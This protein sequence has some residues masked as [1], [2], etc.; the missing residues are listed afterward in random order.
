MKKTSKKN[1][2][3]KEWDDRADMGYANLE[4]VN[5]GDLLDEFIKF[6]HP[7]GHH[8]LIDLGTGTGKVA[9]ELARHAKYVY[10][11]D[12]SQR[13][14]DLAPKKKNISYVC[15][16]A[17]DIHLL[18]IKKTHGIVARMVFHHLN[19]FLEDVLEKSRNMLHEEGSF[20][21]CEGIPPTDRA[22]QN[23]KDTNILLEQ[24]RVF[25]SPDMWIDLFQKNKFKVSKTRTM[26]I[27][28]LSTRKWLEGRGENKKT[29]E[30]VIQLRKNMDDRLKKD[31]NARITKDDVFVDTYWFF[32]KADVVK[33]NKKQK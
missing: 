29:T 20:F 17:K 4:W 30:K 3:S 26:A 13:M 6:I 21:L 14:I 28:N 5:H 1:K 23:W 11:V 15:A 18:P 22:Y 16:D 24:D 12:Y 8:E 32:L 2:A 9:E 33:Q 27:K 10:G 19:G 25:N 7:K 31:W